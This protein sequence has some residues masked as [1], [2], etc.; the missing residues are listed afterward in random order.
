VTVTALVIHDRFRGKVA[1]VTGGAS[2]IGAA[3]VARLAAEG[4]TVVIADIDEDAAR[5]RAQSTAGD[6]TSLPVDIA[7][8]DS[9]RQLGVEL[10]ARHRTVDVLVNCAALTDPQHQARDSDVTGMALDVWN[11]TLAVDLTGTMLTCRE[12]I[13]L[14]VDGG[15]IVNITSNSGLAGDTSL[16]AYATAKGALHQLTRAIATSHGSRGIRCN[17]L[18]PAHIASPSFAANVTAEVAAMLEAN[19]LLPRFGAVEDVAAV[20]AFLASDE[21]SFVT[22][23][24]WRVDGGS[25]AHLP[26]YA[27]ETA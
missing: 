10:A 8:E 25:L 7:S 22:G 3:I 12:I 17:A 9:V 23:E 26:T 15:S 5:R 16:A 6:V 13:P 21:S 27:D 4:A 14:M 18:S 11:R 1:V 24:T 2:G 19:C 20:V